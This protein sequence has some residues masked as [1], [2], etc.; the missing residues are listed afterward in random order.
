MKKAL[1]AIDVQKGFINKDTEDVVRKIRDY[2]LENKDKYDL[3]IF[4]K[5]INHKDSHFV[6]MLDW[7]G[8]ISEKENALAD[9]ILC[10]VDG[11]NLFIKDTYGSFV[12]DRMHSLLKKHRIVQVS[13]LGFDTENCVLSF[14]R[15]AFDRGMRV[16]VLKDLCASHS[17]KKL[18][19]AA[20]EIIEGNIGRLE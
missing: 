7:H 16:V 1:I 15:D 13:L 11:D 19:G 6:K 17:S 12:D 18:H 9:E 5:Y 20:L 2:I 14:A 10:F 8:F 4:T 3:I